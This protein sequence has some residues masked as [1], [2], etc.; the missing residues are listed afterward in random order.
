MSS[1]QFAYEVS[2]VSSHRE[3]K[4]TKESRQT[5]VPIKAILVVGKAARGFSTGIPSQGQQGILMVAS[6]P[7]R[8][9]FFSW[10]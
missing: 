2:V 10:Y 4:E 8:E 1:K 5:T 9:A 7:V 6:K 3:K